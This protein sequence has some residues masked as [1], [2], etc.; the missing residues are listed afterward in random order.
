MGGMEAMPETSTSNA[1][2]EPDAVL[3]RR[4]AEQHCEPAF[5]ELVQRHVG[6]VFSAAVRRLGGDRHRAADVAQVVFAEV[7]RQAAQ[8]AGHPAFVGWLHKT[9]V[10]VCSRVLRTERR[11]TARE[12][13]SLPVNPSESQEPAVD[14][15]EARPLL[16]A[17]LLELHEQ[18]RNA[19]L[20]RYFEGRNLRAIA[21][22][23]RL[24]EDAA[25]MRIQRAMERLRRA[26]S[27]RGVTGTAGA[28]AATLELQA[29]ETLPAGIAAHVAISALAQAA[30]AAT[31]ASTTAVAAGGVEIAQAIPSFWI[32]VKTPLIATC[33][34]LVAVGIPLT[35]QH[36]R[37]ARTESELLQ[38]RTAMATAARS[39]ADSDSP[40]HRAELE[41]LRSLLPELD[42]LREEA[43][44][45]SA[46]RTNP[47]SG[48]V[49][50]A[51]SRLGTAEVERDK[52]RA[53]TEVIR[54]REQVIDLLKHLGLAARIYATD[55][56]DT[57]PERFDQMSEELA[58][59]DSPALEQLERMEFYPQPRRISETEPELF[60]IREKSPRRRPDGS[61]ERAYVLADGSV[62][63]L[64]SAT[65]DFSSVEG[66]RGG[67]A[68]PEASSV[69]P[70]ATS[71][72]P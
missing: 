54:V 22:S 26:L 44:R 16:D 47:V 19:I 64:Q 25:R 67:I 6:L 70:G 72:K 14:W 68:S 33:A 51:L 48:E 12:E 1:T 56:Q 3:L 42:R 69:E 40:T 2:H 21:E 18:D 5:T 45:L 4:Y 15:G 55:H 58:G 17:A 65:E 66:E 46:I 24:S 37:L 53:E 50:A 10:N 27:R 23:L 20:L 38:L 60:L 29:M 71:R 9:T 8:L 30:C 28:L 41:Q 57:F 39:E 7:A 35:S 32:A 43:T 31:V 13:A 36:L 11:R 52:A 59:V 63:L 49:A 34:A 62:Q 61:W